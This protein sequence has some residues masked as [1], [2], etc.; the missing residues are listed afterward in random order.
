MHAAAQY[1]I[2]ILL[3]S[4]A[5]WLAACV[6]PAPSQPSG[7]DPSDIATSDESAPADA[8]DASDTTTTEPECG[9][10]LPCEDGYYCRDKI[11]TEKL[12]QGT[13]CDDTLSCLTGHCVDGM[14]CESACEDICTACAETM[15]GGV[16]G[17]CAAIPAG[18]D[19][20]QECSPQ[21]CDGLGACFNLQMDEPCS[22]DYEC[23]GDWV[24]N[25]DVCGPNDCGDGIQRGSEACDHAGD[26]P[27]CDADC[28]AALCG[29]DY[30]NNIAGEVCDD[31][32]FT[33]TDACTN[34]CSVA[35]CGD[36]SARTDLEVGETGY[37]ACDDGGDSE[38][39]NAD[40]TPAQCG[41]GIVNA[42][43]METCDDANNSNGDDCLNNC[44]VAYC[45]DGHAWQE[46]FTSKFHPDFELCD[47]AG[48]SEFCDDDCTFPVCGDELVN[49]AAGETCDEGGNTETC[50]G[51]CTLP[52][53]GDGMYNSFVGEQCDDGNTVTEVCDYGDT[54]CTV[55]N[56]N[57]E[58]SPGVT[59]FCGD[60]VIDSTGGEDCDDGNAMAELCDYGELS[61]TICNAEC[62]FAA[63]ETRT[64]GDGIVTAPQEYCDDGNS[65]TNDVCPSSPELPVGVGCQLSFCGDGFQRTDLP[66]ED[67]RYEACDDGNGVDTDD[68]PSTCEIA[69]CGDG[70]VLSGTETCDDGNAVNSDD[71][72]DGQNGTCLVAHCGDGF[73]RDG[74]ET[75][76]DSNDNNGDACLNSCALAAC[77]DGFV[78]SGNEEC[79]DSEDSP[80]C[81]QDCTF[82]NCG[83]GYLNL[84]AAETCDDGNT[85]TETCTYG[86]Q[87]CNICNEACQQAPGATSFCGDNTTDT[88]NGEQCDDGNNSTNDACPSSPQLP[89][90]VGCQVAFCGDGF[91]HTELPP[92][93][94]QY[95][96]CDDGNEVDTDECPT[97]CQVAA[98]GDGFVWS[99]TETCDDGNGVNT[100]GCPDGQNGT[101]LTARCGDGFTREGFETCDD[102]NNSN[103]D[104][105]LNTCI[106]ATC[107]DGVIWLGNE[108]CDDGQDSPTCDQDCTHAS[109]GDGHTN[110]MA[111]EHC[112]DGNTSTEICAYGELECDV[113]DFKCHNAHGATQTCGDGVLTTPQEACDDGNSSVND[114]CPSSPTLAEGI[115]CQP[116]TCGDG[117]WRTDITEGT[118]GHEGCD[119][120]NQSDTDSCLTTCARASCGD[121]F[122]LENVEECDDGDADDFDACTNNCSNATCGDGLQRQDLAETHAD[123]EACDAGVYSVGES[124][125]NLSYGCIDCASTVCEGNRTVTQND[126]SGIQGCNVIDGDLL[127]IAEEIDCSQ[128]S[129]FCW[130]PIFI[131][132]DLYAVTGTVTIVPRI[133]VD[134]G[135]DTQHD[136]LF[137]VD[138]PNLRRIDGHLVIQRRDYLTSTIWVM[139]TNK[140]LEHIYL[141]NLESIGGSFLCTANPVLRELK[142][143]SL[144][145]VGGTVTISS[146]PSLC[147]S[148]SGM[149]I[150][151]NSIASSS[152]SI[153]NNKSSGCD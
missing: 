133:S 146:N 153:L 142:M 113:C 121:G 15:T 23:G 12:E 127:L 91:Q 138:I 54:S 48:N 40:C 17:I 135:F 2:P 21:R 5:V 96:T 56:F 81:D 85:V 134:E 61:C 10:E 107:G 11:C 104:A 19:P 111:G 4:S 66:M 90:G 63:G 43:A 108:Q 36:G 13:P 94:S 109:C 143:D 115:G 95:E 6:P 100:D 117:F 9:E 151:P 101:C 102:S 31:G 69:T 110:L 105:C 99:G 132:E 50:D 70:F 55:C 131:L 136:G 67:S 76:D 114:A 86:L 75:C 25:F 45:G 97:T 1:P 32:N 98:C 51:D 150:D 38:D 106:I 112:D 52:E 26:S 29:D 126:P 65:N 141:R 20:E 92:E 116:A 128:V 82:A 103:G 129:G 14:C 137:Y 42:A 120:G 77:G 35:I 60:G 119:D 147:A 18:E 44:R 124:A 7:D 149:T 27:T 123:Y 59:S 47:T 93:D 30:L 3:L 152:S 72:P 88:Q 58:F 118:Q 148:E 87:S 122:I 24:C 46:G 68:C 80:T 62:Q 53:C 71:C 73:T 130:Q 78:W 33:D 39:C 83:D 144:T 74:F 49:Q 28:T 79:D 140:N 89:L 34:A 64:C 8:A 125:E 139:V 57:C 22:A 37:E 145:T 16:D 84:L 41:D